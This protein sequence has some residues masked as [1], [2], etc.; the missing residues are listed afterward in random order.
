LTYGLTIV[1]RNFGFVFI[2][3]DGEAVN[4]IRRHKPPYQKGYDQTGEDQGNPND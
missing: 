4:N 3:G 1:V 2:V